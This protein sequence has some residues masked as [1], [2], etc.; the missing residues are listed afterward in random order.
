VKLNAQPRMT[1]TPEVGS[2]KPWARPRGRQPKEWG[3]LEAALLDQAESLIQDW[4]GETR[5]DGHELWFLNVGRSD[6][7][8]GSASFNLETGA[9]FDLADSDYKGK[10][11]LQLYAALHHM[12]IAESFKLLSQTV[13]QQQ[14]EPPAV[15]RV[16]REKKRQERKAQ[17]EAEAAENPPPVAVPVAVDSLEVPLPPDAHPDLGLVTGSWAYHDK[18]GDELFHVMR[19]EPE[20]GQKET[21]PALWDGERW[22]WSYPRVDAL[23]IF[24]LP[25]VL[26]AEKVKPVMVVE[27]EKTAVAAG[28]QFDGK[29]VVTTSAMGSS[30]AHRSDWSALRGRDV[31]IVPDADEPGLNYAASVAGEALVHGASTVCM[32]PTIGRDGWK[33]GDDLADHQVDPGLFMGEAASVIEGG[34]ALPIEVLEQ[35][36]ATAASRLGP[37]ELD[38]QKRRLSEILGIGTGAFN[39]L[40]RAAKESVSTRVPVSMDGLAAQMLEGN[41]VDPDDDMPATEP[42][43]DGDALFEEIC[44]VIR[45][46]LFVDEHFVH[47]MAAWILWA[48][49]FDAQ[50]TAPQILFTSATKRCGKSTALQIIQALCPRPMAAGNISPASL[51]RVVELMRPVMIVDEADTYLANNPEMVGILNA[52]HTRNLAYVLRVEKDQDTG[53]LTP[54]R[55]STWA[56]KAIAAIKSLTDTQVDRSIVIRL[57][58][59]PRGS[60]VVNISPFA[61]SDLKPLRSRL[62]RWAS[63]NFKSIETDYSLVERGNDARAHLNWSMLASV[64]AVLG[65]ETLVKVQEAF[66]KGADTSDLVEDIESSLLVALAGIFGKK[67]TAPLGPEDFMPTKE[68]VKRLNAITDA[69]WADSNRGKGLTEHKLGRILSGLGVKTT[70]MQIGGVRARG[71]HGSMISTEVHR[72]LDQ[73]QPHEATASTAPEGQ[74]KG[75]LR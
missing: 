53:A 21:R 1:D 14:H 27:G 39:A 54:K 16:R 9:W 62:V 46:H 63:D 59:A 65:P 58:R 73:D 6:T 22:R 64:A 18:S 72:Y 70:Q 44:D 24:N 66:K 33:E 25:A 69:P 28:I 13:S 67:L 47:A 71:F 7:R 61:R 36:V 49:V 37:G 60:T 30:N 5:L 52:G 51:F 3:E 2:T 10:G 41:L 12:T 43:T 8:L 48:H 19:F 57:K 15:A 34:D 45:R 17:A 55:F 32:V 75:E 29:A 11:L 31:V 68:L 40:V 23:P 50:G 42:V 38:R 35:G 4:T 74:D 26:A 20:P 56:P